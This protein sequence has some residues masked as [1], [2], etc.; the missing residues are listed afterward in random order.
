MEPSGA[1]S[2]MAASVHTP[3]SCCSGILL[4]QGL[5]KVEAR[6]LDCQNEAD[7]ELQLAS[8]ADRVAALR[9][10]NN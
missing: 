1:Q 6:L 2:S 5:D 9:Q 4:M 8:L 3:L 10:I 7:L